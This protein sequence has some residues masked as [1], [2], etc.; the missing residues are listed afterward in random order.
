MARKSKRAE[1]KQCIAEKITHILILFLIIEYGSPLICFEP[2]LIYQRLVS[3]LGESHQNQQTSTRKVFD[4]STNEYMIS[5]WM[6]ANY[7][8]KAEM[9]PISLSDGKHALPFVFKL[10]N[11]DNLEAVPKGSIGSIQVNNDIYF[12]IKSG[13]WV[14]VV[15]EILNLKSTVFYILSLGTSSLGFISRQVDIDVE[16]NQPFWLFFSDGT[17][18]KS[19]FDGRLEDVHTI[20]QIL[21]SQEIKQ[22]FFRSPSRLHF[23]AD[24]SPGVSS[25]GMMN[26]LDDIP[27]RLWKQFLSTANLTGFEDFKLQ[28]SD[29]VFSDPLAR[30]VDIS[31]NFSEKIGLSLQKEKVHLTNR[32]FR[33]RS[34]TSL[35]SDNLD[36]LFSRQMALWFDF[37]HDLA[38]NAS[39][40]FSRKPYFELKDIFT[41]NLKSKEAMDN[42]RNIKLQLRVHNDEATLKDYGDGVDSNASASNSV[43]NDFGW[44]LFDKCSYYQMGRNVFPFI[45][46]YMIFFAVD[47]FFKE[48]VLRGKSFDP[49]AKSGNINLFL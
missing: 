9:T 15:I 3:K 42:L 18:S 45:R 11:E 19:L 30:F 16:F 28:D 23:F 36:L 46:S 5:F 39:L 13:D 22:T 20:E 44:V 1:K 48:D 6:Q 14:M 8:Q 32:I 37:Y 10:Y 27:Q 33:Q 49:I 7:D 41:I 17:S 12:E 29:T 4:K 34:E 40:D 2:Q 26:Q 38:S 21:P 47:F 25:M 35:N 31:K 43:P 24:L